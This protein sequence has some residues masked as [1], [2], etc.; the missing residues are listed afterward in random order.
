MPIQSIQINK[1]KFGI[2][3]C[4]F[5]LLFFS[6]CASNVLENAEKL[7]QQK[8]LPEAVIYYEKYYT[9]NPKSEKADY[10]AY[11]SGLIN[12]SMANCSKAIKN[13]EFLIKTYPKSKYYEESY[14]RAFYCPNYIY[15]KHKTSYFGDSKSYGK[16]AMEIV[17]FNYKTF[18]QIDF[19]SRVYAG[20][21]RISA[22]K[23]KYIIN[24]VNI[25]EKS[26]YASNI[27]IKYPIPNEWN[28]KNASYKS[29]IVGKI[30]VK[31]GEFDNCLR[32]IQK[33]G[34][35]LTANYYAPDIGRILTSSIFR[36]KETRIME[37]IKYE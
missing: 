10:A 28:E 22:Q 27:I 29:E 25:V 12:S 20:K 32:V 31:A 14:F 11:M 1:K 9:E 6:S 5:I 3:I 37:L 2:G 15:P 16:N 18:S 7:Y 36:D 4:V 8:R 23:K 17:N 34:E 13:F 33:N 19:L 24:G 21:K 35:A 26:D 30:S